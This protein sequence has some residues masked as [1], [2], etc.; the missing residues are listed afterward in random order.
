MRTLKGGCL[1]GAVEYDI[2]DTLVHAGYGYCSECR[3]FSGSPVSAFWR[4]P[5]GPLSIAQGR[6]EYQAL[7]EE[8]EH[9]TWLLQ[10]VW[11]EPVCCQD[12]TGNDPFASGHVEGRTEPCSSSAFSR[13][14]QGALV[15]DW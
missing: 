8:R 14:V 12:T 15:R 5:E 4:N 1:C 10:C 3:R 2:P 7:C 6:R 9:H 11:I 13:R